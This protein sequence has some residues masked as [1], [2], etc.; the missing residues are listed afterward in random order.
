MATAADDGTVWETIRRRSVILSGKQDG[1]PFAR[2]DFSS[3]LVSILENVKV[4]VASFGPLAR[5]TEWFLSLKSDIA[6]DKMLSA[7]S[8]KVR[9]TTFY[10]SSAD[11]SQFP[12]RI[13]WAPPFIPNA[14]IAQA[15]HDTCT[16]QSMK[17]ETSTAKG[18]EGIPTGIRRF[19]LA[20]N[21]EDIPHTF[22]IVCPKT[23]ERFEI[24]VIIAG[25]S[26]LCF[27]CKNTG[28]FRSECVAQYCRK[29]GIY[30]H[31]FETCKRANS[32]SSAVRGNEI[33]HSST[34]EASID[35]DTQ[36]AYRGGR[37][38][39]VAGGSG[40]RVVAGSSTTG[41]LD[42]PS[43]VTTGVSGHPAES[44]GHSSRPGAE[45][46][47]LDPPARSAVAHVARDDATPAEAGS[48]GKRLPVQAQA[49][50]LTVS[51]ITP[52]AAA[53]ECLP[54]SD[55]EPEVIYMTTDSGNEGST[56]AAVASRRSQPNSI[57]TTDAAGAGSV[58]ASAP[59]SEAVDMATD[60]GGEE[61]SWATVA[62]RKRK[63]N[64]GGQVAP[65]LL[66]SPPIGRLRIVEDS[67]C[68]K[69]APR[70]RCLSD[71]GS[72]SA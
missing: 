20:G 53:A 26:P 1:K 35:D 42:T 19:V 61:G 54:A 25:R 47:D 21:K 34:A 29:C 57:P 5:N 46:D 41:D 36:Y 2:E 18:F 32:Y 11:T 45:A 15:L 10:I 44:A 31:P 68:K 8:M 38:E 16:V 69:L 40:Q 55:S 14:A 7:G 28:H 43:V 6:K 48:A 22:F 39:P 64:G 3:P 9:G 60:S 37:V 30:G 71:S 17:M 70:Q 67:P 72:D 50:D 4:N 13:H 51:V 12:A 27:R 65:S 24:L 58:S 52:D 23:G 49:T 33:Q 63:I 62:S 59:E 66:I 56:Q